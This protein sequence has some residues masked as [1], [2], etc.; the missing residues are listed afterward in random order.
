MDGDETDAA[1]NL[2]L[3]AGVTANLT[4]GSV[5]QALLGLSLSLHLLVFLLG[6]SGNC[7]VLW[8]AGFKM[9][10]TVARVFACNLAAA[11]LAFVL[12]LPFSFSYLA[13][14]FHWPFGRALCKLCVSIQ[15]LNLFGSIFMLTAI[16]VQRCASV[17]APVWARNHLSPRVAAR[18][19]LFLWGLALLSIV[20]YLLFLDTA[21]AEGN[22]TL[23]HFC[24][25][26]PGDPPDERGR[27]LSR[28]RETALLLSC[29]SLAFLLPFSAIAGCHAAVLVRLRR[30]QAVAD[31][32]G[33]PLRVTLT[34]VAAFFLCWMPYHVFGLLKVAAGPTPAIRLGLTLSRNLVLFNC[35]L[36]PVIYAFLGHRFRETFKQSL[37][38][39]LERIGLE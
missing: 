33:R 16:S 39:T 28:Q 14:G 31:S 11:D 7:L 38:S 27:V 34:I 5:S 2:S 32:P 26:L 4:G 9:K 12:F 30:G 10:R 13:M 36:N 1:F 3:E 25:R 29:F 24:Y 19:S 6:L 37:Q 35:C 18:T 23:C 21:P 15:Y 22:R 17:C 20:P 8:I